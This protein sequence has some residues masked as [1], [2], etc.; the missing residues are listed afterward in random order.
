MKLG[1]PERRR[2]TIKAGVLLRDAAIIFA[3]DA[4]VDARGVIQ[5]LYPPAQLQ[6]G[7]VELPTRPLI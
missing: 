2:S 4:Q 3:Q 7:G 6:S 5:I 1:H